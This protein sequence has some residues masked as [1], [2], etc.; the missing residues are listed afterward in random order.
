[1]P[2]GRYRLKTPTLALLEEDGRH[3][4]H[5]VPGGAIVVLD[6]KAGDGE[7]LGAS[8]FNAIVTD[9]FMPLMDGAQLLRTLLERG[10]V[11]PA[12]VLTGF[13]DI[14]H[15]VSIVHDLRAFWFLEKP[16]QPPVL[17]ALLERAVR[18]ESLVREAA[19]LQRQA[20]YH[21]T[22]AEMVGQSHAM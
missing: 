18:Q 12:I 22:L 14:S 4:A 8:S 19:M 17:H 11:T 2:L 6:R 3:V 9:L 10:D 1:M 13:G 7:K 15:A 21:G 5:T 20:G 16:V